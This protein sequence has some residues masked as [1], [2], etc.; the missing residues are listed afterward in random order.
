M[1][2][3]ETE[4]QAAAHADVGAEV[5]ARRGKGMAAFTR[6]WFSLRSTP[7]GTRPVTVNMVLG[8]ATRVT[9]TA[10][11]LAGPFILRDLGIS[12]RSIL[13]V[14]AVVGFFLTFA[15]IGIGWY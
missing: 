6:N 14:E 10:A 7:Y 8:L 4:L 2:V 13:G 12:I 9:G 15:A 1:S 3:T 11:G 5:E